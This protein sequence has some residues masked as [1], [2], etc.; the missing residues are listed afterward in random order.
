M[1]NTTLLLIVITNIFIVLILGIFGFFIYRILKQQQDQRSYKKFKDIDEE[2]DDVNSLPEIK[3]EFH[4]AIVQRLK[5]A[6]KLKPKRSD[7]FCPNHPDEPGESTCGIC[8]RLFCNVCIKPYKSLHFCRE[9]LPY[10]MG[11]EWDE[12]LTI[13]TS[14]IDPEHGVRLYDRKKEL[15]EKEDLLTYVETHYKINVDQDYI[16]TYLVLFSL[17]EE[18]SKVKELFKSIDH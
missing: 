3:P 11:H 17:K 1:E 10:I 6:Q 12:V 18:V 5:E 2:D 4:P 9:H 15:F 16:E 13:K 8:D 7:L 14:T